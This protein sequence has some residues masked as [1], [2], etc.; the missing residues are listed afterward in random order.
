MRLVLTLLVAGA[1]SLLAGLVASEIAALMPCQSEGL[2]CNLDDAIGAYAVLIWAA[3]GPLI[4][5]VI[6]F[7]AR[8]RVTLAG[9]MILLLA[10][11]VAFILGGLIESWRTVGIEPYKDL[12]Q[13]LVML[14]PA[15]LT[16]IAQWLVLRSPYAGT[17]ARPAKAA[18]PEWPASDAIEAQAPRHEPTPKAG[19]GFTPFPT[20]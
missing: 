19:P 4:F 17:Q 16:V 20:E 3:L 15:A 2:A 9:G 18:A 10:P 7:V 14:V 8:N 6:L 13:V 12:R 11:L 1:L 5:G